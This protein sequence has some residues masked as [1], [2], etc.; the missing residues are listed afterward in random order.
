LVDEAKIEKIILIKGYIQGSGEEET[1]K[2]PVS[3][4]IGSKPV[5]VKGVEASGFEQVLSKTKNERITEADLK[6]IK[7][8]CN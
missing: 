8:R 4:G 5:E 7:E 2:T 3:A 1:G 6:T